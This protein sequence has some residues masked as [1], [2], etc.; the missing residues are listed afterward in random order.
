[1]KHRN[2][3]MMIRFL[4]MTGLLFVHHVIQKQ[5][6]TFTIVGLRIAIE[7]YKIQ[8]HL[9]VYAKSLNFLAVLFCNPSLYFT[10]SFCRL[11]FLP[12]FWVPK[13]AESTER[14]SFQFEALRE[15]L[16]PEVAAHAL[17]VFV[18]A[19]PTGAY[20]MGYGL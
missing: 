16:R 14:D 10:R 4:Y 20:R 11:I 7:H 17:F 19:M 13:V 18:G 12:A 5:P 3:A 1:M 8:E 15:F 2:L 9:V 6:P